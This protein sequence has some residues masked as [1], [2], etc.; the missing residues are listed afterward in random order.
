[1]TETTP[2]TE[3][4]QVPARP[5]DR[6]AG[7]LKAA[8]WLDVRYHLV[9]GLATAWPC[10]VG[11]V[12]VDFLLDWGLDLPGY[13][14]VTLLLVNATLLGWIL[15]TRFWVH[16]R[17][18]S[19]MVLALRVEQAHPGLKNLLV[20]AVQ[21]DEAGVRDGASADLVQVIKRQA[22]ARAATIDFGKIVDYRR[23]RSVLIMA[24][25]ALAVLVACVA[26][27]PGYC[28]VLACRMVN[29]W[30]TVAYPTRTIIHV[31]TGDLT[32]RLSDAVRI[33]ARVEG[34]IP[35]KGALLVKFGGASWETLALTRQGAQDFRH[36]F[37]QLP[38]NL[39]YRFKLGDAVS[40]VYHVNV[41]RP[42][43]VTAASAKLEY[44][45]YTHLSVE[46]TQ[47]LN[48]KVPE[49]TRIQWKLQ[50]D[51][52]ITH[53][54]LLLENRAP[55]AMTLASDGQTVTL[56]E[57]A[58][59]SSSYRFR[60][61][62]KFAG[63][64]YADDGPTHF[65][66]VIPD[67]DPR[68]ELIYP[69][70]DEKAALGKLLTISFRAQDEYGLE[71]VT[72]V[73]AVNDR[74]EQRRPPEALGGKPVVERDLAWPIKA[75]LSE[76]KEGDILTFA[77]EVAN[78]AGHVVRTKSR[79]VQFVSEKEYLD[80]AINRQRK[81]LGQIRP[82]YLQERDAADRVREMTTPGGMKSTGTVSAAVDG[83]VGASKKD[84]G[85]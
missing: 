63:R 32:V 74:A 53:A 42:P 37:E 80:Y 45:A 51:R 38:G 21:L 55:V 33:E 6:L 49:K 65:L 19:A 26:C 18:Y 14:R 12:L 83:E 44:P 52:P 29:P 36:I 3:P 2:T 59:A 64:E 22:S 73:Y 76:L 57:P 67:V 82:L 40:H 43:Q 5:D 54:E 78:G 4:N 47:T 69:V 70:E 20:S 77:L 85:K 68:A 84:S 41:V 79:R 62:W 15:W 16:V 75:D 7:Q 66:R 61:G 17:R 81:Y 11:L 58:E 46:E 8:W 35:D 1:M 9:N 31:L 48:L 50:L 27:K 10:A 23:L 24:G 39:D 60:V 13:A 56:A 25:T 72:V 71:Q 30:A 34:E 28:R